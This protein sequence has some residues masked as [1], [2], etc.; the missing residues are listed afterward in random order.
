[1][2]CIFSR[3]FALS[4]DLQ[5]IYFKSWDRALLSMLP[6]SHITPPCSAL[7]LH[8]WLGHGCCVVFQVH[9]DREAESWADLSKSEA[10]PSL[11]PPLLASCSL[12]SCQLHT[13]HQLKCLLTLWFP[14]HFPGSFHTRLLT[15]SSG[16]LAHPPL[17]SHL[18]F[19][20][21]LPALEEEEGGY[22]IAFGGGCWQASKLASEGMGWRCRDRE[23]VKSQQLTLPSSSC[24]GHPHSH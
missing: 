5:N 22:Q 1:M 9:Q 11:Q 18:C 21:L 10:L 2:M 4:V 8:L 12:S 3:S 19:H 13:H 20:S 14:G 15:I 7:P 6:C 16:L 24:T 17:M 23:E